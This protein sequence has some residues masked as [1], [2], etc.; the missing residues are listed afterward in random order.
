MTNEFDISLSAP[1]HA[2]YDLGSFLE[3]EFIQQ[4]S[5]FLFVK[6]SDHNLDV[7][8]KYSL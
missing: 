7:L 8:D 2:Q 6:S 5:R 4:S 3:T 1:E